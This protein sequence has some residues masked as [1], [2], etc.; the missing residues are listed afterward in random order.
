MDQA[1]TACPGDQPAAPS[2][3]LVVT[4]GLQNAIPPYIWN[5]PGINTFLLD[6]VV[7]R[8]Q[9]RQDAGLTADD[10][11]RCLI[12][13]TSARKPLSEDEL[14]RL[15]AIA[16]NLPE[17]WDSDELMDKV[18]IVIEDFHLAEPLSARH[19][20]QCRRHRP[21]HGGHRHSRVSSGLALHVSIAE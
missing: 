18:K 21:I 2:P 10:L 15:I 16:T 8:Y 20:L 4:L 14:V 7:S 11:R 17:K 19:C 9:A 1:P 12:E 3:D 5:H 13:V 6:L